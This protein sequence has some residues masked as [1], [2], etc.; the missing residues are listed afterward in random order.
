MV[1]SGV[2]KDQVDRAGLGPSLLNA[3]EQRQRCLGVGCAR[4]SRESAASPQG[5]GS[6]DVHALPARRCL[7]R[8]LVVLIES[9]VRRPGWVLGVHCIG[10]DHLLVRW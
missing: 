9:S 5:P 1:V 2:V 8:R 6:L 4:P 3:H 7:D 10:E